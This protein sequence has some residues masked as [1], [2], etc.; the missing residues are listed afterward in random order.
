VK[1][2]RVV[3]VDTWGPGKAHSLTPPLK[4][5]LEFWLRPRFIQGAD[6]S[7]HLADYSIEFSRGR[8]P[9]EWA[10]AI[11]TPMGTEDV[12]QI[13]RLPAWDPSH[14]Q[15]Y[16]DVINSAKDELCDSRTQRLETIV[17]FV[18]DGG[19]GYNYLRLFWVKDARPGPTTHLIVIKTAT[20]ALAKGSVQGRQD[21][22]GHGPPE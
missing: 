14:Q 16:Q 5:N 17:P 1:W 7:S 22:S 18:D 2:D 9:D 20:H 13:N 8:A 10:G 6:G 11:F 21:G 19:V 15:K 12:R 3:I 4:G